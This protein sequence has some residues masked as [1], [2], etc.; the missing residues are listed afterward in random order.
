DLQVGGSGPGGQ[1]CLR[2]GRRPLSP[3]PTG[4][5]AELPCGVSDLP[6]G[7]QPRRVESEPCPSWCCRVDKAV[8]EA[9]RQ[10]R[11]GDLILVGGRVPRLI[12]RGDRLTDPREGS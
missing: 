11:S 3:P 1:S 6:R 12:V 8:D 10:Q 5:E 7:G 2:I 4:I 9:E